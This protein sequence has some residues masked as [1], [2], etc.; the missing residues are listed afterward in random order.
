MKDAWLRK[1]DNY[2]LKRRRHRVR[3]R[4]LMGLASVVVFVTMYMLILPA[5]TLEKTA[6][7]GLEE[8]THDDAC[9]EERLVCGINTD[10]NHTH[11]DS[12]YAEESVLI[13]GLEES[14]GHSHD[15]ACY[16]GETTLVC[17][18]EHEHTEACYETTEVLICGLEEGAGAHHHTED[19]LQTEKVL[20]CQRPEQAHSHTDAC[21]ER[22]LTC[23]REEHQH[24]AACYA[25][26]KADLETAA[27][28]E[29]SV[30]AVT[31]TGEWA[32]DVISI[33]RSQLGVTES[34]ANYIIDETGERKGITRYGQWYGD[35]YG[36]W[37]A[38]FASFCLNYAKVQGVPLNENCQNWIE[39]LSREDLNL[40]V[41]ASP[42]AEGRRALPSAG[43]LIFFDRDGS[44]TAD[45]VGLV[46][47][48]SADTAEASPTVIHTI[49]GNAGN[50]VQERQYRVG[51]AAVMGF[52]KLP[53]QTFFCGFTGHAHD[54][55]C[56]GEGVCPLEPHIHTE[57][58]L[59]PAA[60]T[61]ETAAADSSTAE[62]E[63]GTD[64]G[65]PAE[66]ERRSLT[67]AGA[68]YTV[69]V[70][71]GPEAGLP[72]NVT[73]KVSEIDRESETYRNCLE[74]TRA[75]MA[76]EGSYENV[77]FAR[78]FDITFEADG[79]AIEPAGPVEVTISY[80]ETI[81]EDETDT[82]RTVHFSEEGTEFLDVT[83]TEP[84]EGTT[85]FT[86]TQDSFSVVGNV[87]SRRPA[88][89]AD[90]GPDAIK[91]D[92]YVCIDGSWTCVGSTSTGTLA[93]AGTTGWS[94]TDRDTITLDQVRSILGDYGFTGEEAQ[95]ER[96][97]AYQVK[98]STHLYSD[99]T[100]INADD[101]R[102]LLPLSRHA[103]NPGY[104]LYY[105][106]ANTA[107]IDGIALGSVD[108]SAHG[109]NH[110][111]TYDAAGVVM[112]EQ[113]TAPGGTYVY[114][115]QASGVT[116]WY[117]I[118][119]N[120]GSLTLSGTAV[121][122]ENVRT[123]YRIVPRL[124][125]ALETGRSVDFKVMKDGVWQTVGSLPYYLTGIVGD[126]SGAFITSD[127]AAW[128]FGE[129]GYE[130]GDDPTG[131]FACSY[132]DIYRIGYAGNTDYV[133]DVDGNKIADGTAVQL[134]KYNGSSAQFFR[135]WDA[136]DGYCYVTP[137]AD[138]AYHL[139]VLGGGTADG[140]K[141]AIH[142]AADAASHWRVAD[143]GDG[144]VSFYNRN[145]PDTA[146]IDLDSGN[147]SSGVQLQIWN[148]GANKNWILAQ[149]YRIS[150]CGQVAR[151]DDGTWQIA[152]KPE[153]NGSL[154]VY[155]LPGGDAMAYTDASESDLADSNSY[156]TVTVRDDG[157][158]V[159]SDGEMDAMTVVVPNGG[160]AEVTVSNAAGTLWSA[161]GLKGEELICEESQSGGYT[162]FALSDITQHVEITA[163]ADD[164]AFTVQYYADIPRFAES[165]DASLNVID[166]S[167]AN[168]PTNGGSMPLKQL[169]LTGIGR[170]T[171]QNNGQATQ[172]Y[173]VRT[174]TAQTQV[175]G[176][177]AFHFLESP[178]LEYINT[179]K[180][181][182]NYTLDRIGV[183]KAGASETSVNDKDWTW[184][185]PSDIRLT[186]L[187][188]DAGEKTILVTEDTVI[189]LRYLPSE[190]GYYNGATFYDYNIS[191]GQNSDGR[192]R[193]GTTGINQASNYG[194]S[195]NGQ[196]NWN[197]SSDILAFGNA[198]CGTGMS[199]YTFDGVALNKANRNNADYGYATFGIADRLNSD[200]TIRYN[201]WIV[202][203]KLFNDGDAACKQTYE[204][205][206]LTFNRVGDTYTLSAATLANS[207]GQQNTIGN[208]QYFFNPSPSSSTV[209]THIFTNNFWPMDPAAGR[210]DG[211]WGRI[212]SPGTYAG[213]AE[214]NTHSFTA[215]NGNFPPGDDGRAHNW[216]FGMTTAIS[217]SLSADYT[218]PLEYY[219][220]GDDDLWVFLDDRLVCDI[221]GVHSSFGEYVNLRDYLPEGSSGTHTLSFFYTE[222]GAS[223]STCYMSFTLPSVSSAVTSRDT[224]SL[225]V[226]KALTET[227]GLDF[228]QVPY[229]FSVELLT[230]ENGTPLPQ[231][232]SL[233]YSDG[234]YGT[235]KSGG[236]VTLHADE[237]VTIGGIPAG[238]Y[239]RVTE[240]TTDGYKTTVNNNEGYIASGTVAAG[241]IK[242]AAFVN[243][244][245]HEL[246][247]TGGVGTG[248]FVLTGLILM[249]LALMFIIFRFRKGVH[250]A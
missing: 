211:L 140:T 88:N 85:S 6:V 18:E 22:I 213:F 240:L 186:N 160:S 124:H 104:N 206:S 62:S 96:V 185:S 228:S 229:A 116:E 247:S 177:K 174:Q 242:P 135:I 61:A 66:S 167:G 77:I 10:D 148:N 43:D 208:L 144:T 192:W 191:S 137:V 231:T 163:T 40:F 120:G 223:G 181:N 19:C 102:R 217:F 199:G 125:A 238:A 79:A 182:E 221:G 9:Y 82:C 128:F 142:T 235:V 203:P 131:H 17:T 70:T 95:P 175:Y 226:S 216:F 188:S 250:R 118:D 87:V 7:C 64:D 44:G 245:Y 56:G 59:I 76:E 32:V 195:L 26:A 219:F 138:S 119:K 129:Y 201:E 210:T 168:L 166:T 117:A 224:G 196:R 215:K 50:V 164:P 246:P 207:D 30:S 134:W 100:V 4:V 55:A 90:V 169:Y 45:H 194:T 13:C 239:Y 81:D 34:T 154:A 248:P 162:T 209:Y 198:N 149:Q 98:T 155:Y 11:D 130:A 171:D 236:T 173:E 143:N 202:A 48:M 170:T 35:P 101:G 161:V 109:F 111:R 180:A 21:Y 89:P 193:T 49:E 153:T 214:S 190:S 51:D 139:N 63:S 205:S 3:N 57:A 16:T 47:A 42:D 105:L 113:L 80:D 68:D 83:K 122:L 106:P 74:E 157:H 84:R 189:R 5:L 227:D 94:N 14:D 146:V 152:L 75:A 1:G 97:I 197:S 41:S 147:I 52:G 178:G 145:A 93:P 218:G 25:D 187:A 46:T 123:P 150:G 65:A 91:I 12:C 108:K 114:D 23:G 184:Y 115:A 232:F 127:M 27:V 107:A 67:C 151:N 24:G 204:G 2:E 112:D 33:A 53:K 212:D 141:L 179:L 69:L 20:T 222:R 28:W 37:C 244:P 176:D 158:R 71:F 233:A 92:Y 31:L 156:W 241:E 220:F 110:V 159:Y 249:A 103:E 73:L 29:Q 38:M 243:R 225:T 172:L 126:Q 183:L 132:N 165:G 200:G 121:T 136:G 36:D 15:A 234:T 8:H 230:G 86:H 39:T 54:N 133:M 237:S 78:F 58:C 99:T 60:E 72:E